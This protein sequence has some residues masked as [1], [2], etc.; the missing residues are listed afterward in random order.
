MDAMVPDCWR[1]LK[2]TG[3]VILR[4]TGELCTIVRP[5]WLT[6]IILS[7]QQLWADEGSDSFTRRS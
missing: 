5:T 4:F 6:L 3:P 2:L 1:Q 7:F